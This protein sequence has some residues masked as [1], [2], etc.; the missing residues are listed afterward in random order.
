MPAI[1]IS[2]VGQLGMFFEEGCPVVVTAGN[3]PESLLAVELRDHWSSR[4]CRTSMAAS[5]PKRSAFQM[6]T[7]TIVT[8]LIA[9]S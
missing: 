6:T 2:A 9:A 5:A 1:S 3:S 4:S 8:V 7:T